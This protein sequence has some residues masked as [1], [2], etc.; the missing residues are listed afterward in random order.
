MCVCVPS[1]WRRPSS[2]SLALIPRAR[3]VGH[4]VEAQKAER[5][6]CHAAAAVARLGRESTLPVPCGRGAHCGWS[7]LT[8]VSTYTQDSLSGRGKTRKRKRGNM[9]VKQT[10]HRDT[11]K[12]FEVKK[13]TKIRNSVLHRGKESAQPH[14]K[15]PWRQRRTTRVCRHTSGS[16]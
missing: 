14:I 12:K 2:C 8:P 13:T 4:L 11:Q 10:Q 3:T 9:R 16:R 5:Q 1:L 7:G 15:V 6:P